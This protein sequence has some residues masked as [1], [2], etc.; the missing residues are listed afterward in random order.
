M[1]AVLVY[2]VLRL[3]YSSQIIQAHITN[4]LPKEKD[5]KWFQKFEGIILAKN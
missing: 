4:D 2:H 1:I 3:A 5:K